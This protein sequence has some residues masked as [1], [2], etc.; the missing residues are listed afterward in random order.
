MVDVLIHGTKWQ[1]AMGKKSTKKSVS[2]ASAPA[3]GYL[4]QCRF[5]LLLALRE[6]DPDVL[7]SV[8]KLDDIGFST[9][10]RTGRPRRS[11]CVNLSIT[12]IVVPDWVTRR[13]TSGRRCESGPTAFR[14]IA[15]IWTTS[16]CSW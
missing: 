1:P 12:S 3:P 7:I 14:R 16:A 11:I 6:S 8:E 13:R 9:A 10:D 15:L 2:D 5:A 4:Y